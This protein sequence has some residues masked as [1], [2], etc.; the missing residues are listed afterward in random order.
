VKKTVEVF[1]SESTNI[2]CFDANFPGIETVIR[3][4]IETYNPAKETTK[5][6]TELFIANYKENSEFFHFHILSHWGVETYH[7]HL[8]KLTRED[9]QVRLINPFI[10]SI[11]NHFV[12]NFFR[13]KINEINNWSGSTKGMKD[14]MISVKRNPEEILNLIG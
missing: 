7:Y 9:E 5:T 1:Q 12:I 6:R 11:V 13:L 10:D 4:T 2:I 8:D 3:R 14:L